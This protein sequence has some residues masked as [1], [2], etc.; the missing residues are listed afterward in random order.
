MLLTDNLGTT[1]PSGDWQQAC[2][3]GV[4]AHQLALP[5]VCL[6]RCFRDVPNTHV[7]LRLHSVH[8]PSPRQNWEESGWVEEQGRRIQH[9]E[10]K[11]LRPKTAAEILFLLVWLMVWAAR[12]SLYLYYLLKWLIF[13]KE[14][15]LAV[16]T[17]W[18][19]AT[20]FTCNMYWCI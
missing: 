16:E 1:R 12:S 11:T 6:D 8:V 20:L 19:L 9:R 18:P 7:T 17:P 4:F 15:C 14:K 13:S 2:S 3:G 5:D 10:E